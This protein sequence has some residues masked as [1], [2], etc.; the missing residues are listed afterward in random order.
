MV[1][2]VLDHAKGLRYL[3]FHLQV[4]DDGAGESD[5]DPIEVC[6]DHGLGAEEEVRGDQRDQNDLEYEDEY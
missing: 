1:V 5:Y 2:I 6:G 3:K 4:Q